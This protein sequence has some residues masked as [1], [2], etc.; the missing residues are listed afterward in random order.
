MTYLFL[1]G[2]G[3]TAASWDR[4]LDTPVCRGEMLRPELAGFLRDRPCGY[5]ALYEAFS[6]YCGG[7]PGPV[8]LCGLSLG[9][10]LAMQY[11]IE[12][13]SK[14]QSLVLIGTQ[15]VMPV[16]LLRVQNAVFHLM[17]QRLFA[18]MGFS[19]KDFISLTGSMMD[20]DLQQGLRRIACPTLVVC[21]ERDRA[22]M[23]AALE[24]RDQIAAAELRVIKGAGHAVN[25]DAPE[26]LGASL[27]AF[28][29]E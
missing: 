28:W 15:Y 17:P 25:T 20:L 5:A 12:H 4:V 23:P 10:I 16:K 8:S 24:L 29:N 11:A 14:V 7:I 2:L 13:P 21:G 27:H 18:N 1:H 6:A 19:K 22:N 3:Q 9:G 26:A